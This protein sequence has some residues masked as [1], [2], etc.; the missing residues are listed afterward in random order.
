MEPKRRGDATQFCLVLTPS[1][2]AGTCARQAIRERFTA[3]ADEVRR[4]L[5][6]IVTELVENSVAQGRGRP[7]TVAV[8]MGA[9]SI[10]GEVADHS[11]RVSFELPLAR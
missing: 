11:D 2:E 3:L 6:G 8:A 7:I 10:R 9:D 4:E 5:A 1:R